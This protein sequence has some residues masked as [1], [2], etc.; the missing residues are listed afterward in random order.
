MICL[1]SCFL[2]GSASGFLLPAA[3][4]GLLFLY[5]AAMNVQI[6]TVHRFVTGKD[7][8]A[9]ADLSVLKSLAE[10]YP[11]YLPAHLAR[12]CQLQAQGDPDAEAQK[13]A[14]SLFIPDKAWLNFL[15]RD[16]KETT[17]AAATPALP[18][19]EQNVEEPGSP[20]TDADV[21][22]PAAEQKAQ[23]KLPVTSP[24]AEV[25]TEAPAAEPAFTFEPYHTIDYFASQGIK[26]REE[27]K[28]TDRFGQ[29]LKSF[30]EWLKTLK[31]LPAADPV[32]P[33]GGDRQEEQKVEKMAEQS[34]SDRE[35]ITE[36]MAEVWARQGNPEKAIEIYN[37]LSLL[38]PSKSAYFAALI[39]Q[40]KQ[41]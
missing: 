27:E 11:Y 37:K 12:A 39:E 18:V 7:H 23:E 34:L 29:Q 41:S 38:D 1:T 9:V 13:A 5:L 24:V 40:L 22:V 19:P 26:F 25:K 15:L 36:A 30:T 14:L 20:A 8:T 2:N 32:Q 35:V 33:A 3:C 10:K 16:S 4:Y 17:G 31:K 21:L 28:P 6:A